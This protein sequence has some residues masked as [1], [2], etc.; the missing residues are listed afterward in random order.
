MNGDVLITLGFGIALAVSAGLAGRS[1]VPR[2]STAAVAALGAGWAVSVVT[3]P[4]LDGNRD[5]VMVYAAMDA[6][7]GATAA[8]LWFY[9]RNL[10]LIVLSL[11][12]FVQCFLHVQYLDGQF[13]STRAYQIWTNVFLGLQIITV[14]T[15]GGWHVVRDIYDALLPGA[16]GRAGDGAPHG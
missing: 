3:A 7:F 1:P 6:S 14:S 12:F 5:F 4:I 13:G 11:L 10:W 15:P 16:R 2:L 8:I 9:R